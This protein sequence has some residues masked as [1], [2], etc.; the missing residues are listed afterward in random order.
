MITRI[1][2]RCFE[3]ELYSEERKELV[4]TDVL[5]DALFNQNVTFRDQATGKIKEVPIA[6]MVSL[7][8]TS[9]FSAIKHR[10]LSRVVT[11]YS[12][13]L[14]GFNANEVV[15][16]TKEILDNYDIPKGVSFK[17]TGEMEKQEENMAFLSIALLTAIGLIMLLLV[18]Q[19]NSISKPI[20]ILISIF[21]SFTG[22]LM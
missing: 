7:K 18:F 15:G 16:K 10:N 19:F 9:S 8:N 2:N 6:S 13:V 22:V 3:C 5:E 20:I 14:A 12:P 4:P 11:L 17:F 21:L 1:W